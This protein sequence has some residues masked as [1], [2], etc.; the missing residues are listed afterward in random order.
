MRLMPIKAYLINRATLNR[1]STYKRTYMLVSDEKPV[2]IVTSAIASSCGYSNYTLKKHRLIASAPLNDRDFKTARLEKQKHRFELQ[3]Q[4][5]FLR[6]AINKLTA[7]FNKSVK[8]TPVGVYSKNDMYIVLD[9]GIRNPKTS[10]EP[11][12]IP[13]TAFT[14]LY[15]FI[16]LQKHPS[17]NPRALHRFLEEQSA[18]ILLEG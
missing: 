15:W 18:L 5:G 16:H 9:S 3:A 8:D 11:I 6:D 7:I 14:A 2:D 12:K 17:I 13:D 1:A 10:N 4:N